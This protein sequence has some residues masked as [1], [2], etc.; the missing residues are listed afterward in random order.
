MT[1]LLRELVRTLESEHGPIDARDAIPPKASRPSPALRQLL[2]E[3]TGRDPLTGEILH[4]PAAPAG[5]RR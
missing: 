5:A 2:S 4:D 1:Y 3:L